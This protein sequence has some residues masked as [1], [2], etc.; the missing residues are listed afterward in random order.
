MRAAGIRLVSCP[1]WLGR[2]TRL[3]CTRI[4]SPGIFGVQTVGAKATPGR[5]TGHLRPP[6]GLRD[7][8][9]PSRAQSRSG[10]LPVAVLVPVRG[11]LLRRLRHRLWEVHGRRLSCGRHGER[12]H[13]D[14]SICPSCDQSRWARLTAAP[15]GGPN[16]G[17]KERV[18]AS[19]GRGPVFLTLPSA[20]EASGCPTWTVQRDQRR[21]PDAPSRP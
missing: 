10:R 1:R 2:L 9:A 6:F 7:G 8:Q 5:E 18:S 17:L 13:R 16:Y 15:S 21:Q 14:R 4:G 12:L 19:T 11:H 3:G 20:D